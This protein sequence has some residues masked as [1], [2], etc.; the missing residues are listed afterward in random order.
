MIPPR[1]LVAELGVLRMALLALAAA[2]ALLATDPGEPLSLA[3]WDLVWTLILPA[4]APLTL[5]VLLFD[6][7]MSSVRL[8]D[9]T[10]EAR[11]RWRRALGIE[12]L[13][14][15]WLVAA[16][17]PFFREVLTPIAER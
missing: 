15:L 3:G 4:A 9:S 6:I 11:A 8:A 17:A 5:F 7:L 1:A 12:T 16:W 2:L 10:A 13:F 14:A